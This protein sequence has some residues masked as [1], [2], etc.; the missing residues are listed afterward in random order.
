MLTEKLENGEVPK[1]DFVDYLED[2]IADKV[3]EMNEYI[4][5]NNKK[6]ISLQLKQALK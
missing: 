1:D 4:F 2:A 3:N 5:T 6:A